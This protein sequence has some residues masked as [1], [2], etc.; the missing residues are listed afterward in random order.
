MSGYARVVWMLG[1]T[2]IVLALFTTVKE[3]K[4]V[5]L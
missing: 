5:W 3:G 2:G 1:K 4:E